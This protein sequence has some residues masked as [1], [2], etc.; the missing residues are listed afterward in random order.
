MLI[1]LLTT[2]D[3]LD[4]KYL[5]TS[6][7]NVNLIYYPYKLATLSNLNTSNVNV[8]QSSF[9][10]SSPS[11]RDLNTSNVNVNQQLQSYKDDKNSEF[12]YI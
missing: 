4:P 3:R 6:N 1:I 5:N 12:K 2:S 10:T 11:S 9:N 8:N 7:V